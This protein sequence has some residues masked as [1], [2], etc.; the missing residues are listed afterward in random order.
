MNWFLPNNRIQ[1]LLQ[2]FSW[3]AVG[4][5]IAV[6][7]SLMLLRVLTESLDP[8]KFGQLALGLTIAGLVNAV[9]MGG[10][11]NG[12]GRFYSVAVEKN[13]VS[14]YLHGS[15]R[16]ISYATV[17]VV[18]IG[19]VMIAMLIWFGYFQ[20]IGLMIAALIFSVLAS[21]NA[22]L[23]GIQNAARQRKIV[24]F[25][26]G[27][28]PWLKILFVIGV[29]LWLGSSSTAV[30]LCYAFAS[31]L[32]LISQL[33]FLRHLPDSQGTKNS[34]LTK[35][36]WVRKIWLFSWPFII[37]GLPGWAQIS[38]TR[39][40]LQAFGSTADVGYYSVLSQLGYIPIQTIMGVFMAFITPVIYSMA[41][42]ATDES[43]RENVSSL[44]YRMTLVGIVTVSYTHLTLPTIYSV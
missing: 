41:G 16:I 22:S 37:W 27:L 33:F 44:V 39:W 23:N 35:K 7:G 31:L 17:A 34:D 18:I 30:V 19:L 6:L 21:Y 3:V 26:S 14:G 36:D 20:W 24:A 25:H 15:F 42:S 1:R 32:L 28:D 9:I 12:I 38:S 2:E 29:T 40:A 8:T 5:V 13:D 10:L 11:V 4:Q 43:R